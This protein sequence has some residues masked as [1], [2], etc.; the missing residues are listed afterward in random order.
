MLVWLVKNIHPESKSIAATGLS[1]VRLDGWCEGM[2]LGSMGMTVE[3]ARE[4]TKY[5]KEW[6]ALVHM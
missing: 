2:A 6:I 3:A 5:R 4:C 1:K